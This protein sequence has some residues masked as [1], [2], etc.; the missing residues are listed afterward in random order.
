MANVSQT[1]LVMVRQFDVPA[2]R[3]FDAWINPVM[4]RRWL[5]TNEGTNKLAVN[6]PVVG[7]KW[8]IVDHRNGNDYTATGEYLELNRPNRLVFTFQMP[9]FSELTDRLTVELKALDKGCEMT[10]TQV[11]NVP[12]EEN[13]TQ[14]D[15]EKAL[16]EYRSSS[17]HGWN[18]MF[19]GLKDILSLYSLLQQIG[20]E[21]IA[22]MNDQALKHA[23]EDF[24]KKN[25]QA[26]FSLRYLGYVE[27]ETSVFTDAGLQLLRQLS[28]DMA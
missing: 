11:I 27:Q 5:M 19:G 14:A 8:T 20:S 3:V 7:G 24:F 1:T 18:L 9:Q 22:A 23:G 17:E 28:L 15:I 25:E 2:E 21:Q 13:W 6:E 4:M 26:V 10:F 16:S 12:H